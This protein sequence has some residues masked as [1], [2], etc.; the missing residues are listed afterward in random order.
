MDQI[1]IILAEDHQIVRDGIKALLTDAP[2]I[3]IMGEASTGKELMDILG[4][5][6]TTDIIIMDISLPDI[7]GIDI[8]GVSY[9]YE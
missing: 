6:T 9:F 2:D 8:Q 7:S 1:R 3:K 4:G 5:R